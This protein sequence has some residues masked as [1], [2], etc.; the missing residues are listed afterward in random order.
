[1]RAALV[2][3]IA[4]L[5]PFA[6]YAGLGVV[7]PRIL[8]AALGVAA[9]ARF[10]FGKAGFVRGSVRRSLRTRGGGGAQQQSVPA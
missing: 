2:I 10:A 6:V 1:M 9:V 8:A 4:I 7:E 5:Y 3:A